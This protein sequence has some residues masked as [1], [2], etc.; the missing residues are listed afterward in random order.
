MRIRITSMVLLWFLP[1][2]LI[3]QEQKKETPPPIDTDFQQISKTLEKIIPQRQ[4]LE[5]ALDSAIDSTTYRLGPGD[6]LLIKIW[7]ALE[8]QFLTEVTPEGFV[9]LP[10]VGEFVVEGKTLAE[11]SALLKARLRERFFNSSF[12]VRLVR[13]RKFRV[14]VTGEVRR[15]GTYFM[16][17]SDRLSDVLELAEG[18][19]NWG[20]ETQIQVRHASGDTSVYDISRFFRLGD[21]AAN[22][23]LQ[24]GDVVFVPPIDIR[25]NF[26]IIEG[27]VGSQGIYPTKPNETIFSFLSRIQALN[28]RS[29]IERIVLIRDGKPRY[30]NLLEQGSPVFQE[31]LQKGDRLIIPTI[32]NR[33]YVKGEVA[34]P[35]P[36]PYLA[37]YVAK[38]YAGLAGVLETARSLNDIYVIR[39]KDGRVE[40]GPDVIVEKGDVVVVPRRP[41][42]VLKDYLTILAPII[43]LGLSVYAITR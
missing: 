23:Y 1:L 11:V 3:A 21:E 13:I 39:T 37:H 15:P 28:R 4:F 17:P 24:A 36:F 40:K 42:E 29:E 7:G 31:K 26:V 6:Q 18:L 32:R 10:A 5:Q 34:Q 12:A 27:N 16:R 9:I 38:D 41:R 33:V 25:K 19:S 30:F 22:P 20:N 14:Y 2:L 43:S 8:N 35:G